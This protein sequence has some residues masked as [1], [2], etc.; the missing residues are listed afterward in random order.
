MNVTNLIMS[1][2]RFFSCR[3]MRTVDQA[4]IGDEIA[5]VG[6]AMDVFDF[7]EDDQ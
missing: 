3:F 1:A 2:S 5:D 6:E 7:V 4:A